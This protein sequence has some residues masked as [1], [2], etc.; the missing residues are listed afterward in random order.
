MRTIKKRFTGFVVLFLLA[1]LLFTALMPAREAYADDMWVKLGRGL[2]NVIFGVSEIL[3]QPAE[4]G[5]VE[6]W[7][8]AILGGIPKGVFYAVAREL[9]GVYE[10]LTFPVPVPPNFEPIMKPEFIIS[11]E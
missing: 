9:V 3:Y 8:I 5:K 11:S 7:P 6:R 10:V 1:T 2:G 4:L